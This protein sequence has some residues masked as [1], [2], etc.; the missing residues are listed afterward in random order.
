MC[1][2]K[3]PTDAQLFAGLMTCAGCRQGDTTRALTNWGMRFYDNVV[4]S[5]HTS[6]RYFNAIVVLP[7]VVDFNVVARGSRFSGNPFQAI[8]AGLRGLFTKSTPASGETFD[9]DVIVDVHSTMDHR[10]GMAED[11]VASVS[12]TTGAFVQDPG[13]RAA[14]VEATQRAHR[15]HLNDKRIV[16]CCDTTTMG[17]KPSRDLDAL[18]LA[19]V[20]LGVAVEKWARGEPNGLSLRDGCQQR[21]PEAW[22]TA[23]EYA[24]PY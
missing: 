7:T 21:A 10:G 15:V 8:A 24:S 6:G 17:F 18:F 9:K 16:L 2:E 13:I 11:V 1:R 12:A 19:A 4:E 14:L 5:A 20:A 22:P 3:E 23:Q